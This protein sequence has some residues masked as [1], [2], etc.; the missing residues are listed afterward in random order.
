ML[1]HIFHIRQRKILNDNEWVGWLRWM[2][3]AFEQGT[4]REIWENQIEMEKWFD[5]AFQ[6]F[7]DKELIR[8][9]PKN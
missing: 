5:P 9:P 3:S 2:K 8:N 6:G 4:I 1:A 7:I